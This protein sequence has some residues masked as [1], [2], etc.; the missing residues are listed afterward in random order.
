MFSSSFLRRRRFA[1]KYGLN[2]WGTEIWGEIAENNLKYGLT[3]EQLLME[4]I[5]ESLKDEQM[6]EIRK[7]S[8]QGQPQGS[9]TPYASGSSKVIHISPQVF[10]EMKE[11][12]NVRTNK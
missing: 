5:F 2:P 11:E 9:I 1:E 12:S 7:E 10:K 6:E 3:E 8:K 4:D